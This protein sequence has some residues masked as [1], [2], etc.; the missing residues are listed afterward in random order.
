MSIR[1]RIVQ[2]HQVALCAAETDEEP[3]DIYLDDGWHM[4]LATKFADDWSE[5]HGTT[6][7]DPEKVAVMR[8][9]KKRDARR[10]CEY[11]IQTERGRR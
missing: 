1:L 7:A 8:T 11:V 10:F 6:F 5:C 2:G 3:G 4:A 9:Q